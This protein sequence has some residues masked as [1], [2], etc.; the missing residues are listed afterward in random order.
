[1]TNNNKSNEGKKEE[2]PVEKAKKILSKAK[3]SEKI[4]EVAKQVVE[5]A[6]EK[7]E[8][9]EEGIEK[10]L[11]SQKVQEVRQ[12]FRTTPAP[13]PVL[14][15]SEVGL[16]ETVDPTP[17][18]KPKEEK[19]AKPEY[20]PMAKQKHY[21]TA[22]VREFSDIEVTR[23]QFE[24]VKQEDQMITRRP[25]QKFIDESAQATQ[26]FREEIT[27][28]VESKKLKHEEIKST[29]RKEKIEK[30]YSHVQ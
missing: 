15:P 3:K 20:V 11:E 9:L 1:M 21:E 13:T 14:A 4:R 2:S 7:E 6:E 23:P 8:T 27:T 19:I 16:E 30:Y 28:Y 26:P 25:I 24:R 12:E 17:A 22:T 29:E 10:P 18:P 5:K